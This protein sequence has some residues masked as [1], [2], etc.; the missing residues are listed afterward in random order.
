M[1]ARRHLRLVASDERSLDELLDERAELL[2]VQVR[3]AVRLGELDA[4]IEQR[5]PRAAGE[6]R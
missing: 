6:G 2:E 3:T 4:L 5:L 1:A